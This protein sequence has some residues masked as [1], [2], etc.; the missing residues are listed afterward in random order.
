MSAEL[1]TPDNRA[2]QA[3]RKKSFSRM[4]VED[5]LKGASAPLS[6]EQIAGRLGLSLQGAAKHLHNICN[7]GTAHNTNA[8]TRPA[9]YAWG[10]APTPDTPP[11][12]P[13]APPAPV[14]LPVA[15]TG[16]VRVGDYDGAMHA[17]TLPSVV[18]G[19]P[20]ERARPALISAP[21][22]PTAGGWKYGG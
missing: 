16:T 18:N 1:S 12:H 21:N 4:A 9:L 22:P 11:R 13:A 10:A 20:V 19:V 17:Y 6:T 3:G 8:G 15:S 5:W 2:W 7:S 14:A